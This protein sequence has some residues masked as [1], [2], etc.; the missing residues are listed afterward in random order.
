M[1]WGITSLNNTQFK[2]VQFKDVRTSKM[3]LLYCES[4]FRLVAVNVSVTL[5]TA[6]E[7]N[8]ISFQKFAINKVI[9][10]VLEDC[11]T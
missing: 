2:K 9:I 10:I 11:C 5:G 1:K 6:I 4:V 8:S 3:Y 7:D